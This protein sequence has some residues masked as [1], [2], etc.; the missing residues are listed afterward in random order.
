MARPHH[1]HG[2]LLRQGL[3]AQRG[4]VV[5][6]EQAR[7]QHVALALGHALHEHVAG[8]D[9]QRH[10][11][12]GMRVLH[13]RDGLRQQHQAGRGDGAHA[14]PAEAACLQRLHLIVGLVEAGQR[15]AGVP[16]H[17]LAV[18]RGPHAPRQAVE[19][20]HVEHVLEVLQQLGGRRLRHVEHLGG[21][22]DVAFLGDG[23][24]QQ[25]L[26]RL[27]PRADEPV[28]VVGHGL[29]RGSG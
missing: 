20:R 1:R 28:G 21:A 17:R 4:L 13:R 10:P 14:D 11:Q 29:A 3:V 9:Q 2:R 18:P 5:L 15:D 6:R 19:Q 12:A 16:D 23:D 26:A 22:V 24:Q 27:E 7:D 8:L 25:Q